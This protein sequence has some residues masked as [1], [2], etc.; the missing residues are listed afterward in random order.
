MCPDVLV[1][2]RHFDSVTVH[3]GDNPQV[4]VGAGCQIWKLVEELQRHGLTT[5]SLGLIK[6]QA[7]AGATATGTHGSGRHSLSHYVQSLRLATFDPQ[8]GEPVV[9][10]IDSGTELQAARC[11]LGALGIVLSVIL[12]VRPQYQIEEHFRRY[13]TLAEVLAKEAEYDLQQFFLMP[14][15]W[16]FFAQHRRVVDRPRS[17]LAPLYRLY[18]SVGMDRLFHIVIRLLARTSVRP[19]TRAFFRWVAP[20]LVPRGWKVVDRS[21]RQLTMAHEKFRHIEIEVFVPF[22]RLAA[23]IQYVIWVLQ[24]SSGEAAECNATFRKPLEASGDWAL[25]ERLKGRYHHHYPICIRKVLADDTLI[26]MACGE[27]PR[28]AISFISY[29][30][31][32]NRAGFQQ[33]AEVL[34]RTTARLFQARPH[35]GKVCPLGSLTLRELYPQFAE[36]RRIADQLDPKRQFRNPWLDRLLDDAP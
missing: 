9:R 6:Q 22:S 24:Y 19:V 14:W 5:P 25:V 27:E 34:A 4:E 2:L 8:S 21:D 30:H 1:D 26:S 16:D 10:T 17:G 29:A 15:R 28:Y 13:P 18:W 7:I 11:S 20:I 12:P 3:A 33:F 35:W 32:E 23:A 36:F 31:P